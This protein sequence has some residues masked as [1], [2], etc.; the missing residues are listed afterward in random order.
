MVILL[1]LTLIPLVLSLLGLVNKQNSYLFIGLFALNFLL[2]GVVAT[3]AINPQL[4]FKQ[5]MRKIILIIPFGLLFSLISTIMTYVFKMTASTILVFLSLI[6][7]ILIIIIFAK[8]QTAISKM[9][10]PEKYHDQKIKLVLF[11]LI[12]LCIVSYVGMEVPPFSVIPLWFGL[13]VPFIVIIPGYLV[14]NF[15]DPYNDEIMFLERIGISFFISLIITSIIGVVLTQLESMLNMRHVSLILV[16]VTLI[17]IIPAYAV[18]IKNIDADELFSDSRVNNLFLI[19]TIIA[20]LA[21]VASGVLVSTG[22]VMNTENNSGSLYQG[23]TTFDVTGIYETPG[24]DGY[25][26]FTNGEILNLSVN[27]VNKENRDMVYK[28]KVEVVND[29]VNNTLSEEEI[30]LTNGENRTIDTN[31]TMASGRKDIKFVLYNE[32]DQPYKIR[33]L[34]VNVNDDTE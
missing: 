1:I 3:K 23:N 28:L 6:T 16:I 4:S 32:N 26:T 34:Y 10:D 2:V 8:S 21:V 9:N 18:R 30:V 11:A 17:L 24:D 20:I 25:Y 29:T 5:V 19:I 15:M 12:I 22:S 13:C 7:L 31:V 14:M 27:I 33:H